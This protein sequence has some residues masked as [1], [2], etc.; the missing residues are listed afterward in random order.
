MLAQMPEHRLI[1]LASPGFLAQTPG[2]ISG[3]AG[4]LDVA[5][6]ANVTISTLDPRGVDTTGLVEASR[7]SAMSSLER[8]NYQQSAQ[9]VAD[10]LAG[11]AE[12]TGGTFFHNNN[13]LT[14]GFTRVASAL[15]FLCP[16]VLAWTAEGG[17]EFSSAEDSANE[18]ESFDCTGEQRILRAEA[19][20]GAGYR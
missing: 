2:T 13:D 11:L 17:W 1:V 8:E 18:R 12:C 10:V 9:A 5:A 15:S 7:R 14:I 19:G 16:R 3:F 20:V 6:R 4:V